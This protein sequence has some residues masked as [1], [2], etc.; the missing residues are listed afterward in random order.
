[1][2][3]INTLAKE[4]A[5]KARDFLSTHP[6]AKKAKDAVFTAVGLGIT[7]TQRATNA[8][9]TAPTSVDTDGV[10]ESLR[11]AAGDVAANLR[12]GAALLDSAIAPVEHKLP[13]ALRDVSKA[14][15]EFA[16]H[17]AKTGDAGTDETDE[18]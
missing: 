9:R 8:V 6:A 5:T 11:K 2:T 18:K 7:S 10:H 16:S 4:A 15:R 1:M 3:D 12:K 17:F 14:A 13:S